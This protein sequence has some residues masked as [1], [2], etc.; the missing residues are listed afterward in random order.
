MALN[1]QRNRFS[2]RVRVFFQ[3]AEEAEPVMGRSV[4]SENL[5]GGFDLGIHK[6][7]NLPVGAFNALPGAVSKL[8]DQFSISHQR[9]DV[10][11]HA[12]QGV[13]AVAIAAAFI[14]EVQTVV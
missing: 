3:P 1:R 8:A 13:H 11:G 7:P 5:L 9:D 6:S 10:R 4:M 2:G 12:A 14:C